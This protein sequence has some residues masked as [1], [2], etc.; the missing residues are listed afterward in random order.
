LLVVMAGLPGTGK[1]T[2]ARLLAGELAARG[3]SVMSLD[4]DLVRAALFGPYEIEY[5][6]QQDDFC[7]DV[8]LQ[9]TEY[10][11]RK[12]LDQ[13]LVPSRLVILDGRTYS[14]RYQV[15]VVR[16]FARKLDVPCVLIECVCSDETVRQRLEADAAE[17]R[18]PAAN[19]NYAMYLSVKERAEPIA[20]PKLVV[21]TEEDL[22]QC[23]QRCL[24]Y[25]GR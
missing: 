22:G 18:H 23:V 14:R 3:L 21:N 9:A 25:I 5:S 8:M 11:L 20:G 4:K 17:A 13:H 16:S 1:S 6:T 19:R 15:D 2:V 7:V 12:D 10:V 24:E